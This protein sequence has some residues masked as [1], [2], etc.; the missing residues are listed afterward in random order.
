MKF[1]L[2]TTT[3]GIFRTG[4]HLLYS[5]SPVVR[6]FKML[7]AAAKNVLSPSEPYSIF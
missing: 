7:R 1:E 4:D 6:P 2:Q 5:S 3:M